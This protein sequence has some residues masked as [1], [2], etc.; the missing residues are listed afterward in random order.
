MISEENWDTLRADLCS[1]T[2]LDLHPIILYALG[3]PMGE[4]H[5]MDLTNVFKKNN[6]YWCFVD[7]SHKGK[8]A[9]YGVYFGKENRHNSAERVRGKQTI[10]NAE[11]QAIEHAL[12]VFPID[13]PLKI[14]TDSQVSIDNIEFVLK[15]N[16][17][18]KNNKS[19]KQRENKL[20]SKDIFERIKRWVSWR[21]KHNRRDHEFREGLQ[22]PRGLPQYR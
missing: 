2:S 20:Y 8:E 10:N 18:N 15:R 21:A 14:F 3:L 17:N 13:L 5:Q 4:Q 6:E 19:N 9:G 1:G 22:S 16:K 12:M 7:G 11:L